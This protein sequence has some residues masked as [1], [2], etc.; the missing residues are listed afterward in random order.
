MTHN[1]P[2]TGLPAPAG[3]LCLPVLDGAVP[4]RLA[5]ERLRHRTLARFALAA[6]CTGVPLPDGSFTGIEAVL[7]AQWNAFLARRDPA[8]SADALAGTP[9]VEIDDD[10]L[11]IVIRAQSHLNAHRLRPV[12]ERLEAQA[13][14]L[15]WFVEAVFTRCSAH[16]L[17]IYDMRMASTMLEVFH[18]EL[19]E[20][21]DEAYARAILQAQGDT[22]DSEGP[23]AQDTLDALRTQY[24]F[25]PSELL[26]EVGGHGH[27]LAP[28][29]TQ[30]ATRPKAMSAHAVAQWLRRHGQHACAAVV[31][32]ALRLQRA[33]ARDADRAFVW[34]A[35]DD[36]TEPLGALCFLAWDRPR[37]LLEAVQ[38]FEEN[39]YNGG[40]A[41]EAFA[42]Q[43]LPLS[44]ASDL[45]LQRLARSMAAYLHRWHLLAQ[46]LAHFPVWEDDDE[47]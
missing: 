31:R 40:Q 33:L 11:R 43:V 36:E 7:A 14:G 8:G 1:T 18:E 16:G 44:Q 5:R 17:Q 30:A 22:A 32:A 15:G 13:P 4:A 2:G 21:T 37:L 23:I 42:R 29:H 34:H 28:W 26:A 20:F 3:C 47:A 19:E 39:Q 35:F 6:A 24:G 38:H 9:A 25:W 12:I 41:V 27:L 45:A 46:L 10:A